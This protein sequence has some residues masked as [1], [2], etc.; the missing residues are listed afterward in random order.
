MCQSPPTHQS[1]DYTCACGQTLPSLPSCNNDNNTCAI[2]N[3]TCSLFC[4]DTKSNCQCRQCTCVSGYSFN[5]SSQSCDDTDECKLGSHDCQHTCSNT[6]GDFQCS[7]LSGYTL[8]NDKKSC[9]D[10]VI[11]RSLALKWAALMKLQCQCKALN[12]TQR[13]INI[14]SSKW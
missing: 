1:T 7:C 6:D 10:Y 9:T 2:A 11:T 14:S 8:K 13:F 4:N 12:C 3:G 5:R